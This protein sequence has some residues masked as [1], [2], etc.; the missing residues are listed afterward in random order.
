[1]RPVSTRPSRS[2]APWRTRWTAPPSGA[3]G[4]V[5]AA[6][7]GFGALARLV[8]GELPRRRLHEIARWPDQ[9]A[10]DAAIERQL[11]AADGV[12]HDARRVRRVPDFELQL[13]IQR[14]VAEG[15]AFEPDI[16]PF[17]VGQPRHMVA[18]ADMDVVRRHLVADLARHRAG[19]RALLRIEALALEH[20]EEIGI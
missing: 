6:D 14:H 18:R 9:R 19:L 20:V 3:S 1:M 17:A 8:I 10:A 4:S 15:R 12:D 13:A 2:C 11:G 5:I 16:A 7:E